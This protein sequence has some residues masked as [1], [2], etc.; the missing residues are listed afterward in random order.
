MSSIEAGVYAS[1]LGVLFGLYKGDKG[2]G[3]WLAFFSLIVLV[4]QLVMYAP[5]LFPDLF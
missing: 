1:M 3:R 5:Q 2:W 4:A